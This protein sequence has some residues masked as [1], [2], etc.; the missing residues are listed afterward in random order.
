MFNVHRVLGK[1]IVCVSFNLTKEDKKK[2]FASSNFSTLSADITQTD[3]KSEK[4][5]LKNIQRNKFLCFNEII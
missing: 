4:M 2:T 1:K 5:Y 3:E